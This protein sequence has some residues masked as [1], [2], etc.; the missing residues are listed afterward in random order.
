MKIGFTYDLKED[1]VSSKDDPADASAEFDKPETVDEV[2]MALE[3]GG[4]QVVRIG[5]IN[6]LTRQIQ[7]LDVDIV[8]NIC[9]GILGRNRESQVPILLEMNRIP[10]VGSDALTQ[11]ITLDKSVAKKC[12]VADGIRTPGYLVANNLSDLEQMNDM[13]FP[14]FV[15]PCYEGTSKSITESSCVRDMEGL[16]TQVDL[17]HKRYNQPALVEKFIRGT[18]CTVAVIGNEDAQAMPVIQIRID[19][20]LDLGDRFYK[21]ADVY[22]QSSGYVCPA[23]LPGELIAEIQQMALAVYK[24]V[25]CRDFGRVDF[26]I[27]EQGVPY[28]LE[29]NPLPYLG[30]EDVFNCFPQAR[31]ATYEET[32]NQILNYALRRCGLIGD[33]RADG[34]SEAVSAGAV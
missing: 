28:V 23:E 5:G 21:N 18:E 31:G 6:N 30:K 12:F 9:E 33:S 34:K 16:R 26:R 2:I 29:I 14:L 4:H 32:I 25:G 11:A 17:I 10:Y 24:S 3:A 20:T 1:W 7:A 8:F 19:G 27:D 15:K 22:S 13:S